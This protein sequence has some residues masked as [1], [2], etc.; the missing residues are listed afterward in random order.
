MFDIDK[1]ISNTNYDILIA[2]KDGKDLEVI[3]LEGHLSG[4]EYVK[5][6]TQEEGA[7]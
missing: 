4:L 3:Y 2:K 1:A 6:F 5:F 7:N